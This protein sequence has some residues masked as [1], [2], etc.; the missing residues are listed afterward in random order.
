MYARPTFSRY[1]VRGRKGG[2]LEGIADHGRRH[3]ARRTA[4]PSG[5]CRPLPCKPE[6]GHPLGPGRQDHRHPHSGWPPPLSGLRDPPL[7]EQLDSSTAVGPPG[8]PDEAG[9]EMISRWTPRSLSRRLHRPYR[10]APGCATTVTISPWWYP[11]GRVS[12]PGVHPSRFEGPSVTVSRPRAASGRARAVAW[13]PR[14]PTWPTG[15]RGTA[16]PRR[17]AAPSPAAVG[18]P[19][20]EVLI[21]S[22]GVIGRP[23]PM[24]LL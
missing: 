10:P 1:R 9:S 24:D 21:A 2:H 18:I 11:P 19:A 20:D 23:Y 13:S 22:T 15:P 17:S 5:G 3:P 14:T 7:L 12:A 8:G 16:T 6:D 4:H